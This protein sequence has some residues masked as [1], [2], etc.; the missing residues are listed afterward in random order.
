MIATNKLRVHKVATT[1]TKPKFKFPK[2][3]GACADKL[4]ELRQKRLEQQKVVDA[5][6]ALSSFGPILSLF[7]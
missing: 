1:E 4:Y 6:E 2:Q 7:S 5:I 3:M